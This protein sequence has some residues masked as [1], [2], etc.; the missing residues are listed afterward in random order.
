MDTE[1]DNFRIL[2][3]TFVR[4]H[5]EYCVILSCEGHLSIRAGTATGN[6]VSDWAEEESL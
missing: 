6:Q 5:M 4:P 2:Y 1:S 3:K